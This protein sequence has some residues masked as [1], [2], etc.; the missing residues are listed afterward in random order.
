MTSK[1]LQLISDAKRGDAEA[2]Y[3]VGMYYYFEKNDFLTGFYWLKLSADNL[4]EKACQ[5]LYAIYNEGYFVKKDEDK[6]RKYLLKSRL[7]F[8]KNEYNKAFGNIFEE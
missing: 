8:I 3:L 2:Q 1:I 4:Y 6:A 7:P 5:T